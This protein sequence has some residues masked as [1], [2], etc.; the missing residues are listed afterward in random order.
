MM[1]NADAIEKLPNSAAATRVA[2]RSGSVA[3]SPGTSAAAPSASANR[4]VMTI[5]G[6]L[7]PSASSALIVERAGE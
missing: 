7:A 4:P 1:K 3:R 6:W 2:G 5:H